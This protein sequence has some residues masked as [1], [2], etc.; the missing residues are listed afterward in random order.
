MSTAT[1]RV[2]FGTGSSGGDPF[3]VLELDDT[4]NLDSDG[5][6][7]TTFGEGDT[8]WFL[9]H[10]EPG[11][12]PAIAYQT[13]GMITYCGPVTRSR[14]MEALWTPEDLS[15]ELSHYPDGG[16]SVDWQ[17]NSIAL[18]PVDGRRLAAVDSTLSLM[19]RANLSYAVKFH[20][21]RFDPPAGLVLEDDATYAIDAMI[22]LEAT[23]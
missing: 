23:T 17:G 19:A 1:C 12:T 16:V 10:V 5:A 4:L 6:V 7:K 8:I 3:A 9:L 11:Y 13:D 21:Y 20:L 15:V 14:T 18:A 22:T 2:T